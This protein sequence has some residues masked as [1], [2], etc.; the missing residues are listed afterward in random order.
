M[1]RSFYDVQY[2]IYTVAV[3]AY[4]K[5][6]KPNYT[7]DRDF[8]GVFY[9]FLRGLAASPETGGVFFDRPDEA[10]IGRLRDALLAT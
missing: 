9:F 2:L 3:D 5:A 6:R 7:Y 1:M 8:G 10:F 4:L